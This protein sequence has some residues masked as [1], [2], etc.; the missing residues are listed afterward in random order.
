MGIK[1]ASVLLILLICLTGC[2]G[3]SM[4]AI[5]KK[6]ESPKEGRTAVTFS[7]YAPEAEKVTLEST[8]N[9][10]S[11]EGEI[12]LYKEDGTHSVTL[13]LGD[14]QWLYRFRVDGTWQHDP[15]NPLKAEAEGGNFNSVLRRDNLIPESVF[16]PAIPHG[17]V[18]HEVYRSELTALAKDYIV[19]LPPDYTEEKLYPLLFLLHGYGQPPREFTESAQIQNYL[20]NLIHQKRI[21]PMVV[22]MPS[23]GT[24]R[25]SGLS[26][27]HVTEELY[28]HIIN[29]Y[30]VY[31]TRDK[32]AIAG[33]SMGGHGALKLAYENQ[34]LFGLS[35]PIMMAGPCQNVLCSYNDFERAY[36]EPFE[37]ELLLYVGSK[38]NLGFVDNYHAF[39]KY[40]EDTEQ[41]YE[42]HISKH[43]GHE[44]DSHGVRYYRTVLAEIL[45]KVSRFFHNQ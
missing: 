20:D 31:G 3:Q 13:Y 4:S 41:N 6:L 25:W 34:D 39:S 27:R 43:G 29:T 22:I 21:E 24:S 23:G 36:P 32:T 2:K 35:A 8:F 33:G 9:Y 10:W 38:D 7:L 12:V 37:L 28:P 5:Q 45:E 44:Q 26:G 40:L 42:L 17:Q 15:T 18:L 30:S 16:N 14:E 19:Y 1:Q 11:Q